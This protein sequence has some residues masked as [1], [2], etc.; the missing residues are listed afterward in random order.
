[1]H[2]EFIILGKKFYS[3]ENAVA[4]GYITSFKSGGRVFD[5]LTVFFTANGISQSV[6]LPAE[7]VSTNY[8]GDNKVCFGFRFIFPDRGMVTVT[9]V[10]FKGEDGTLINSAT[11][12]DLVLEGETVILA[13]AYARA[14]G[15]ISLVG[16]GVMENVFKI[17]Q[18]EIKAYLCNDC[19]YGGKELEVSVD[20]VDG[21]YAL[22]AEIPEGPKGENIVFFCDKA[23]VLVVEADLSSAGTRGVI[24]KNRVLA[25]EDGSEITEK[26]GSAISSS[27]VTVHTVAGG[28]AGVE[29]LT[30]PFNP[31]G[32]VSSPTDA[33]FAVRH[34]NG[35]TLAVRDGGDMVCKYPFLSAAFDSSLVS[36]CAAE[37]ELLLLSDALKI[38]DL[39]TGEVRSSYPLSSKYTDVFGFE[40]TVIL[41]D[42]RGFYVFE[43]GDS[44]VESAS[45]A[46][47]NAKYTFDSQSK[48][49]T[50]F[51]AGKISQYRF[52][53]VDF[54]EYTYEVPN[55]GVSAAQGFGARLG[56]AVLAFKDSVVCYSLL[57]GLMQSAGFKGA[58]K[59]T[60]D[61]SGVY[62]SV[63]YGNLTEIYAFTADG[64]V[65]IGEL[66]GTNMARACSSGVLQG[67][68]IYPYT[69]KQKL[70]EVVSQD[71]ADNY[72]AYIETTYFSANS[73]VLTFEAII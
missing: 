12:S 33:I 73:I 55:E 15:S 14:Y 35:L 26:A 43:A 70:F 59:V 65:K 40:N 50:A 54:T 25:I 51:T 38:L 34:A 18:G 24:P 20:T 42:K 21:K 36:F 2:T 60:T 5:G 23:P 29:M 13:N 47:A 57:D 48:T 1:M 10:S 72:T 56:R 53:G 31:T 16:G 4:S 68:K 19:Y 28:V 69:S 64:Y 8:L 44:L 11:V 27:E 49:L 39:T 9:S 46:L 17:R 41:C 67:N 32:D 6:T 7:H 22:T 3:T 63:F 37:G 45:R 62:L 30:L 58:T 61:S 66:A 71:V 52:E